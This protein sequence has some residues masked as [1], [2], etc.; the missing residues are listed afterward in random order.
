[1]VIFSLHR[2]QKLQTADGAHSFAHA[3]TIEFARKFAKMSMQ[4]FIHPKV[5]KCSGQFMSF[6]LNGI[7]LKYLLLSTNF[8]TY[9]LRKLRVNNN[10]SFKFKIILQAV[11]EF[12]ITCFGYINNGS[13]RSRFIAI[14]STKYKISYLRY[15]I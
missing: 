1:M 3:L 5:V 8:D 6:G 14:I 10:V 9:H 12:D 13:E 7:Y 2:Q 11:K 4:L 15:I